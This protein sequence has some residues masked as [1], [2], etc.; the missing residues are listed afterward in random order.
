MYRYEK[1]HLQNRSLTCSCVS[2]T[3]YRELSPEYSNRVSFIVPPP[4]SSLAMVLTWT[5]LPTQIGS[6]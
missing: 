2:V 3:L 4:S 1:V 6:V 5:K